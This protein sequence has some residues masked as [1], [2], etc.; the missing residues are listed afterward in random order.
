MG[1]AEVQGRLWG[2]RPRDWAVLQESQHAPIYEP[3]FDELNVGSGTRLLDAGCGAGSAATLATKRGATVAGIDAS[4]GLIEIAREQ[5]QKADLRVG[6]LE[7]LPFAD[8]VFNA[9]SAFNSVQFAADPVAALRELRRVAEPG[10]LVAVATWGQPG[11]C[12][13]RVVFAAVGSLLPPP[14]PGAGGPFALSAPGVLEH[15]VEGAGLHPLRAAEVSAPFE[16][17]DVELAWRAVASSSSGALAIGQSGEAKAREV[18]SE[19]FSGFQQPDGTIRLANS[20]R[21]LI[22]EA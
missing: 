22:A 9:V 18:I 19:A 13:M 14:P 10:A 3:V 21:Y 7:A 1:S 4:A 11:A 5:L 20:F 17:R 15:L 16:Y 8:G 2:T 12:E 6:D